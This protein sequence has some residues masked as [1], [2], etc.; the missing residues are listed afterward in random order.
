[1]QDCLLSIEKKNKKERKRNRE[2]FLN[3]P[4]LDVINERSREGSPN[5][6]KSDNKKKNKSRKITPS[7]QL[8]NI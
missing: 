2:E 7:D 3:Q 1:M 8:G 4:A 6:Q 5:K